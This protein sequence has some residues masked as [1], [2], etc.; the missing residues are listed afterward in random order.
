MNKTRWYQ[1]TPADSW[2]FRDSRPANAGE[3]Q[4]DLQSIF[5]PHP[6]TIVGAIRAALARRLGW[7][8][9]PW[10][11][12]VGAQL[13]DGF[14]DVSPLRF[15]PSMLAFECEKKFPGRELQLMF[16]PPKHL[17]G[18]VKIDS[19][20]LG[21]LRPGF[22]PRDWLRPST[23]RF[24]TDMG[25]VHLPLFPEQAVDTD[26]KRLRTADEF[27]IT[28]VGMQS[29]LKGSKPNSKELIHHSRLFAIENRIGINRDPKKRSLYS[30]GHVRLA[31]G[32]SLVI[33]V[34]G[35]DDELELPATFPLGGESRQ[36][37]CQRLQQAPIRPQSQCGG[38]VVLVTPA[39]WSDCWYGVRPG[40]S[41]S[42]LH[43]SLAS[44]V[45]T[46][47]VDR[48]TRIGGF[49]SRTKTSQT[50]QAY[51][52]AGTVWWLD[53]SAVPPDDAWCLALGERTSLGYGTALLGC[54]PSG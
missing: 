13:G 45:T 9:G 19:E 37:V 25:Q 49:D 50:L 33:G 14:E 54:N 30:P 46:C 34:D 20:D 43:P 35:L 47:T 42:R 10:S 21:S 40:G 4:S 53:E 23:E 3:D 5:P 28:T 24:V 27:F 36:A 2:F 15:T 38:C 1:I 26:A 41:A 17:V 52:P 22:D 29:V 16:A 44:K 8:G 12:R 39:R 18:V 51:A 31:D 32:V 11:E 48:P 7:Q 6:Q